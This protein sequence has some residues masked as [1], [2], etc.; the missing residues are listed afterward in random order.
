ME[1]NP[2]LLVSF[3]KKHPIGVGCAFWRWLFGWR[4]GQIRDMDDLD[5]DLDQSARTG[6]RFKNNLRYAARLDEHVNLVNDAAEDI[7]K[8][9]I[10]PSALANNLQYFY[11]LESELD[12][13]RLDLRQGTAVKGKGGALFIVVPYTVAVAGT[14]RQVVEFVRHLESGTH[15][16]KFLSSNLSPS[17]TAVADSEDE[18]EPTIVLSLNLQLLGIE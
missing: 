13:K 15:F 4:F 12:L 14:Y 10:N 6:A 18:M 5:V 9:S 11:R 17:R 2:Q 16:V 1:F 7:G 3:V 8:R